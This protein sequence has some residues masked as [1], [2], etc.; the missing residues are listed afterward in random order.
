MVGID[1]LYFF[2]S[3][4]CPTSLKGIMRGSM[5]KRKKGLVPM[6]L[7]IYMFNDL[8]AIDLRSYSIGIVCCFIHRKKMIPVR[9]CVCGIVYRSPSLGS[10][11]LCLFVTLCVYFFEETFY[12]LKKG[13]LHPKQTDHK[14][15]GP[16]R[17]LLHPN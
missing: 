16:E 8:I 3:C 17:F 6:Y 5:G 9:V 15:N 14:R 10:L 11:C 2:F 1:Y 4:L 12:F 13:L 7:W